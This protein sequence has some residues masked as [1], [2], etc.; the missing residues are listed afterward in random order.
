MRISL[1]PLILSTIIIFS[2]IPLV[3]SY[4]YPDRV[5]GIRFYRQPPQGEILFT[6]Q[7][8]ISGSIHSP[9]R[10]QL[11]PNMRIAD[12]I[13]LAGGVTAAVDKNFLAKELN[14]AESLKDEQHIFVPAFQQASAPA[15]VT[16][17]TK[18]NINISSKEDL[19]SLPGVG[20]ST[21]GAI[22]AARPFKSIGQLTEVKGIGDAKWQELKDLVS[23]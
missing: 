16:N 14:L 22:I 1:L 10:Y 20:D 4:F 11:T 8:Y 18:V 5:P 23:I 3:I 9:G 13:E 2:L 17:S 21:A 15:V 6:K 12:L 19:M 7:V